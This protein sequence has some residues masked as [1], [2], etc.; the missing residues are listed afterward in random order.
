MCDE[1]LIPVSQVCLVWCQVTQLLLEVSDVDALFY[2]CRTNTA[3]ARLSRL[4]K[5]VETGIAC[6]HSNAA[7]CPETTRLL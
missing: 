4:V 1:P 5:V 2:V 3:Q 6:L 7:G